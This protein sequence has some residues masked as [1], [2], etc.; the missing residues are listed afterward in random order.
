MRAIYVATS[1]TLGEWGAAV[2]LT[3]FVFKVGF[4][5]D[6]AKSAVE[7]LNAAR[8]AGHEDWKLLKH[9]DAG[10]ADEAQALARLAQKE[11][12]V[13]PA[14]YP[15]IRGAPGIFKVKPANVERQMTVE[16]ALA[17]DLDKMEKLKPA[18]FAA[19]L[20]SNALK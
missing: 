7:H 17:G 6:G 9:A 19:Y 3:K 1:K 13:D 2:G 10:A 15:Q 14:L 8:H 4:A 20:I 12:L 18:D 11:K 5:E 16:R